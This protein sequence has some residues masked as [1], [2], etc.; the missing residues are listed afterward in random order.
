MRMLIFWGIGGRVERYFEALKESRV[1]GYLFQ[2]QNYLPG[3]ES[4]G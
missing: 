1:R 3:D 4:G 2:Q